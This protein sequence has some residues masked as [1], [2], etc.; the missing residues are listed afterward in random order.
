M[1]GQPPCR[2][3]RDRDR[4]ATPDREHVPRILLRAMLALVL[5]TLGLVAFARLTNMEPASKFPDDL[6][7][8]AERIV[9]IHGSITGE[10]RVLDADGTLIADLGPDEGGF[11]AGVWRS[12]QLERKPYG[13]EGSAPVRLIKFSD[14]RIAL[15]D[16]FT[17]WRVD[18][19]GFG[20]D[21]T[22][23]FARLLEK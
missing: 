6:P 22:A 19:I 4:R 20:P 21:N 9:M 17:D 8:V 14:G 10:A 5:I 15:H 12:L 1:I 16:E 11:V 2:E 3:V 23:V 13:I 18:L 7:V